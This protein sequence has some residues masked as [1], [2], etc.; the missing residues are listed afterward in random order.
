MER[1]LDAGEPIDGPMQPAIGKLAGGSPLLFVARYGRPETA[2]LLIS[3]GADVAARTSDWGYTPLQLASLYQR[4]EMVRA[5]LDGGADPNA[6]PSAWR[7][8]SLTLL[9]LQHD[10]RV[11]IATMLLDAGADHS[12]NGDRGIAALHNAAIRHHPDLV[13]LLIDRGASLDVLTDAGYSAF[14]HA[15]IRGHLDVAHML[16]DAGATPQLR[17][18]DGTPLM[19]VVG[20]PIKG[21]AIDLLIALGADIEERDLEGRTALLIAAMS[22]NQQLARGLLE[23]GASLAVRDNYGDTVWTLNRWEEMRALLREY[24]SDP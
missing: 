8:T 17:L 2:S 11:E 4:P 19:Q 20:S 3:R 9:P 5:L 22:N 13:R 15:L 12:A 21:K 6:T 10:V 16:L 24:G 1:L 18:P 7:V 14:A 23:R